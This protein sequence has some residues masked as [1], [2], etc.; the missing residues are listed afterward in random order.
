MTNPLSEKTPYPPDCTATQEILPVARADTHTD[1]SNRK[2][3]AA[4]N[5]HTHVPQDT[6]EEYDVEDAFTD[7]SP[8]PP[9]PHTVGKHNPVQEDTY[10]KRSHVEITADGETDDRIKPSTKEIMY[11]RGEHMTEEMSNKQTPLKVEFNLKSN[12][13]KF[14]LRN[15]LIQLILKLKLA[16]TTISI[17]TVNQ[18][19]TKQMLSY[20]GENNLLPDGKFIPSGFHL[21]AGVDSMKCILREH[22]Q[23]LAQLAVVGIEGLK[24]ESMQTI[25]PHESEA[26]HTLRD[27]ILH[28]VLTVDYPPQTVCPC[29]AGT[30]SARL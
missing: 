17:A 28:S 10:K 20:L 21:M 15:E 5:D 4:T 29:P 27:H 13:T 12:T 3:T 14:N 23:Y 25:I 8:K 19:H 24:P 11:Q 7:L 22:N 16:D 18:E 6:W 26:S 1:H 30:A 9:Q 2:Q